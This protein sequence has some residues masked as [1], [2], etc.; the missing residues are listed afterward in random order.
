MN[1]KNAIS[2]ILLVFLTTIFTSCEKNEKQRQSI[3]VSSLMVRIAEIEVYPEYLEEYCSILKEEARASV[4]KEI[5]VISILPMFEKKRPNQI[6]LLEIYTDQSA[7]E[8]HLLTPHFK[9]YKSST[10]QMV[11]SLNLIDMSTI[12]KES[13]GIIFKKLNGK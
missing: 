9:F 5:G 7:Y 6:R 2:I 4:E 1:R 3:D 12:D 11:K 8:K 10:A 13:M